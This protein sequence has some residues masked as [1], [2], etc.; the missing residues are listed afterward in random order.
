VKIAEACRDACE[1][2]P[3]IRDGIAMIDKALAAP[4][5]AGGGALCAEI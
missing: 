3:N 1:L 5:P 4:S 2:S